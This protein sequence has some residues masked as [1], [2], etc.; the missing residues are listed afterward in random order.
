[1]CFTILRLLIGVVRVDKLELYIIFL[2]QK[3]TKQTMFV[4]F[5]GIRREPQVYNAF[6]RSVLENIIEYAKKIKTRG[7]Y[8]NI[9]HLIQHSPLI[10]E[11]NKNDHI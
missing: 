4:S 11:Y 2:S 9:A 10:K 8:I 7:G 5:T 3:N 6:K 1:M